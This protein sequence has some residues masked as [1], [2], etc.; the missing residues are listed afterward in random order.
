MGELLPFE[1]EAAEQAER[2]LG[3]RGRDFVA[4]VALI[5]EDL[6][7]LEHHTPQRL[8][9]RLIWSPLRLYGAT[10]ARD[11]IAAR[12]RTVESDL[13]GAIATGTQIHRQLRLL[14][15]RT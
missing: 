15:E 5:V 8:P 3:P 2:E 4:L 13:D 7:A 9:W 12:R 11:W 14:I 10:R 6:N 1:H